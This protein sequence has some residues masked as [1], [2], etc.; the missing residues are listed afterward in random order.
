MSLDLLKH[1]MDLQDKFNQKIHPDWKSELYPWYRATWIE[2]AELVDWMGWKWWKHQETNIEQAK[3]E[4]VDIF[5]FVLSDSIEL[6]YALTSI[7]GAFKKAERL[8]ALNKKKSDLLPLVESY[9]NV[10]LETENTQL[11]FFAEV[12]SSFGMTLE[13]LCELYIAKNV[14]NNFRQANGY[15]DGTYIKKWGDKEDNQVLE[16]ILEN[17]ETPIYEEI[18][19][20]LTLHYEGVKANETK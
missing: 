13:E 8:I 10:V 19:N 7:H 5:H 11:S 17:T 14:L 3:I 6:G 1:C 16:Y 18:Y 4:L 15:K 12:V 9:A 2:C 20:Q